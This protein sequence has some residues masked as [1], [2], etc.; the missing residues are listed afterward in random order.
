MLTMLG[1]V[2][3]CKYFAGIVLCAGSLSVYRAEAQTVPTSAETAN[4]AAS[5]PAQTIVLPKGTQLP[6]RMSGEI[7]SRTAKAGYTFHG[8]I[9]TSVFRNGNVLIP[10]GAQV[11]GR[12]IE[13]KPAGHLVGSAE[14]AIELTS[15]HLSGEQDLAVT[16]DPVSSKGS[17]R[18]AN[19]ATKAGGGAAL[20][21]IIGALAGG[22]K[23]AAI[24]AASGG[25]LGTGANAVTHGQVIVVRP[26]QLVQF[27]IA[28]ELTVP[29]SSPPSGTTAL[30]SPQL[31]QRQPI[32]STTA[33]SGTQIQPLSTAV[34]SKY[35]ILGL[36]LGMTA[37][38]ALDVVAEKFHI[39]AAERKRLLSISP[40][41]PRFVPGRAFAANAGYHT[42]TVSLAMTFVEVPTG[43]GRGPEMLWNIVYQ[44]I[45]Q[46][47]ADKKAFVAEVEQ[48]FGQAVE[49]DAGQEYY[50]ADQNYKYSLN[51]MNSG[52]PYLH[53]TSYLP[54]LTLSSP[55]IQAHMQAV[56][57]SKKTTVAPI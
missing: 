55:G 12:I 22:G 25:A 43:E 7:S 6:V 29:L 19:T 56:F 23:G 33:K 20:G 21:A 26:E 15:V 37:K 41:N 9:A 2:R 51:Y 50:W 52:K 10:T 47:N 34:E 40:G 13:A 44:P 27:A 8:T 16:T 3:R 46:T 11:T 49:V 54:S 35:D 48:K 53:L 17:G 36:K 24:G 45:L 31:Q 38:E 4:S 14:L 39:P 57:N 32:S 28:S 42:N 30:G 1:T 5:K 18:G